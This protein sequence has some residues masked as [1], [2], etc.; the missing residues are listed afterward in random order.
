MNEIE[1]FLLHSNPRVL[2]LGLFSKREEFLHVNKLL[3]QTQPLDNAFKEFLSLLVSVV[4]CAEDETSTF[5]LAEIIF[6]V[7]FV[8]DGQ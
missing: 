8:I 5:V 2:C 6:V 1:L 7:I 3:T 4:I